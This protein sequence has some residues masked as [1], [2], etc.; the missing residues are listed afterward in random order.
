ML[1]ACRSGSGSSSSEIDSTDRPTNPD[2][3]QPTSSGDTITN[4]SGGSTSHAITADGRIPM[5]GI[6]GVSGTNE[7]GVI[8]NA[9]TSQAK[10]GKSK[11]TKESS[12]NLPQS[13]PNASVH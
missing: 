7:Q 8:Y 9:R 1:A 2:L 13:P 6:N 3:V 12:G 11:E 5:S 4:M 10:E